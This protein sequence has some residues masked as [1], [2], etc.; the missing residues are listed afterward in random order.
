MGTF[1]SVRIWIASL[2]A[3]Y[4]SWCCW[5]GKEGFVAVIESTLGKGGAS[6]SGLCD[7]IAKPQIGIRNCILYHNDIMLRQ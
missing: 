7:A 4:I 5:S 2:E 6:I 3:T 1:Q